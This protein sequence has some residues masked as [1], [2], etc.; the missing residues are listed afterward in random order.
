MDLDH[1]VHLKYSASH[2]CQLN[3]PVAT[4][5]EQMKLILMFSL[6]Q[7]TSDVISICNWCKNLDTLFS[8]FL[9][10]VFEISYIVFYT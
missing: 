4:K 6:T 7:N 9:N 1:A 8:L 3:I 5:R 2:M 10:K